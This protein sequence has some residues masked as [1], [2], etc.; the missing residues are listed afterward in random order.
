MLGYR[1]TFDVELKP[2]VGL[3]REN[4]VETLLGEG[5]TWVRNQKNISEIDGLEP[6]RE[7]TYPSGAAAV[8]AL[9]QT[10]D[11]ISYGRLT[12][13]DPPREG[14]RWGTTLLVGMDAKDANSRPRVS[15]EVEAPTDPHDANK[16]HPTAV[17][18]LARQFLRGY[19]CIE[20]G[21]RLREVASYVTTTAEVDALLRC[22]SDERR[23]NLVILSAEDGTIPLAEWQGVM[24]KIT[25]GAAGQATTLVLSQE[26]M[27][28]FNA[29]VSDGHKLS[30]YSPRTFYPPVDFSDS[31][32]GRRHRILQA[33][34]LLGSTPSFLQGMYSRVCREHANAQPMETVF[35][36]LEVLTS[37]AIDAAAR[38][39]VRVSIPERRPGAEDEGPAALVA[40]SGGGAVKTTPA[41][42]EQSDVLPAHNLGSLEAPETPAAT[43]ADAATE[44]A[45]LRAAVEAL[46]SENSDLRA[47]Q[48]D[49]D[50]AELSLREALDQANT[51]IESLEASR[52]DTVLEAMESE[53]SLKALHKDELDA[54][55]FE[56]LRLD[57]ELRDAQG[58]VRTLGFQLEQAQRILAENSIDASGSRIEPEQR[59]TQDIGDWEE[60]QYFGA[61]KF[62]ELTFTCDWKKMMVLA[63]RDENGVW[64]QSTWDSLAMLNDYARFKGTPA[65]AAFAGGLREYLGGGAPADAHLISRERYRA[66]ES[67]QVQSNKKL[68]TERLFAVPEAVD[69]SGQTTMLSHI[70]IQ[71]KGA[72]SPRLYFLDATDTIGKIVIGYIGRHP[73]N[74]MTN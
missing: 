26:A 2:A 15:I 1:S 45:E 11:G 60:I 68:A 19:T 47:D 14:G 49:R 23:R 50:A 10:K 39:A 29:A 63:D 17:P 67:E 24:E 35:R 5:F 13:L 69:P 28:A 62:P 57:E 72:L 55:L 52:D 48:A 53:E 44:V 54:A 59:Y 74:T 66:T 61:E 43:S 38:P 16:P 3:T 8:Y 73:K 20:H 33:K 31:S 65:G 12:F 58:R 70:V 64:F 18:N 46:I 32:D 36:R 71:T 7:Q 25:R 21:L 56:N 30:L 41:P 40:V 42:P 37:Q 27:A 9:G 51:A 4:A 22:L 34:S 6:L